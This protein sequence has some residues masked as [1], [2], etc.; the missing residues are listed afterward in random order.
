M[1]E[2]TQVLNSGACL[3]ASIASGDFLIF[4]YAVE[5]ADGSLRIKGA[6]CGNP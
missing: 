3:V 4:E 6:S 1:K 5:L 2:Y